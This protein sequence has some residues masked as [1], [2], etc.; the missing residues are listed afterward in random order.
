MGD[1]EK[2]VTYTEDKLF[3][4]FDFIMAVSRSSPARPMILSCV[5]CLQASS[6][7]Q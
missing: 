3:I 7:D 1:G 5:L 2:K 6:A 4:M